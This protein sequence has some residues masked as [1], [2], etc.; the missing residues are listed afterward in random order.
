MATERPTVKGLDQRISGVEEM[1]G[2][3]AGALGQVDESIQV[4]RESSAESSARLWTAL[5]QVESLGGITGGLAAIVEVL[6]PLPR[7]LPPTTAD[8]L[9][10]GVA[11]AIEEI[12]GALGEDRDLNFSSLVSDW[13]GP[14]P[15]IGEAVCPPEY[16]GSNENEEAI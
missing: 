5:G 10:C 16:P 14:V 13:D 3:V 6:S 4:M 15:T 7:S 9:A 11:E 12:R 2:E 1:L 8:P